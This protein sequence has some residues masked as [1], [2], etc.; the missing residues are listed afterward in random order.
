MSKK[1]QAIRRVAYCTGVGIALLCMQWLSIP[2][3][4]LHRNWSDSLAFLVELPFWLFGSPGYAVLRAANHVL[5]SGYLPIASFPS[6]LLVYIREG[7]L[8][9]VLRTNVFALPLS[10]GIYSGL[11]VLGKHFI[12]RQRKRVTREVLVAS[13]T[14]VTVA[15]CYTVSGLLNIGNKAVMVAVYV[16]GAILRGLGRSLPWRLSMASLPFE[17]FFWDTIQLM[18]V[19]VFIAFGV[20]RVASVIWRSVRSRDGTGAAAH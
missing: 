3:C 15:W 6:P 8:N 13:I 14:G 1:V 19:T 5:F 17:R 20:I 16:Q 12:T 9:E 10:I 2:L 11:W 18:V 7:D 4:Q